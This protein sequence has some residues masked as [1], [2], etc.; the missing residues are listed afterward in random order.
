MVK[1]NT[2]TDIV[3]EASESA[4]AKRGAARGGAEN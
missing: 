4:P 3:R 1:L 2:G